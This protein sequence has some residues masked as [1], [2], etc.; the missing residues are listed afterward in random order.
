[1]TD[2]KI[3]MTIGEDGKVEYTSGNIKGRL[4]CFLLDT[5]NPVAKLDCVL[6]EYPA[7]SLLELTNVMGNGYYPI[8]TQSMNCKGDVYNYSAKQ[9]ILNDKL[10][11]RA[12]GK[13]GTQIEIVVRYS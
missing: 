8:A 10:S 9:Y 2:V 1:M 5:S 7:I 3:K 6:Q 11:F 13:R 12:M 4:Q